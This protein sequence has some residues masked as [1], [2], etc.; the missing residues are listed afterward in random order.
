[1][2]ARTAHLGA[3]HRSNRARVARQTPLMWPPRRA[4][5]LISM[6]TRPVRTRTAFPVVE[7]ARTVAGAR[8]LA[9]PG[10]SRRSAGRPRGLRGVLGALVD[11]KATV[12]ESIPPPERAGPGADERPR[13]RV[14]ADRPRIDST[15]RQGLPHGAV[16][17]VAPT[18]F[19]RRTVRPPRT[20]TIWRPSSIVN[21]ILARGLKWTRRF[22][23][24]IPYR[25]KLDRG[26][27][28]SARAPRRS[29]GLH[30]RQVQGE[31]A[32]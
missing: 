17:A 9:P 14:R 32:A 12:N 18:R 6:L 4:A 5:P 21:R 20:T 27:A 25:T 29:C 22:L 26:A 24:R 8:A 13:R 3:G 7:W 10:G 1:M 30:C 23:N 11:V 31:A 28:F 19:R 15:E 16:G 2:A